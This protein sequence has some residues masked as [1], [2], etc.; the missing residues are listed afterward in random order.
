MSKR[1]I[2]AAL[3]ALLPL[4]G[5]GFQPVYGTRAGGV[6]AGMALANV[7]IDPIPD[8]NGQV[9]RNNLIDRFY[10]DG[11][12]ADARYRL[13]VALSAAEE[14][15][16]IQKDATATRARLRLQANY[17]L[18]DNHSGQVVY[19]TFSRSVISFNL[20]D[21]QFAVLASR[22]GAYDRGLTEL[23]D[24]IRTRLSLYFVRDAS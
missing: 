11:R 18:I 14:Q 1:L 24:D 5:C 15:L 23:A 21:S 3:I 7:Q 17:E 22:Q 4:A 6:T 9:L 13:A 8:R 12:P 19:R 2:A 16:G 20:L 10:T